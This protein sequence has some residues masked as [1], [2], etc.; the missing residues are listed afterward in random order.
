MQLQWTVLRLDVLRRAACLDL[1][2]MAPLAPAMVVHH[3][4]LTMICLY[5][6]LTN[7]GSTSHRRTPSRMAALFRLDAQ[8]LFKLAARDEAHYV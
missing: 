6:Q 1:D 2:P 4:Q 3:L 5:A 7:A 8:E